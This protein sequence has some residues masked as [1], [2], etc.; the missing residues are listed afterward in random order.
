[1]RLSKSSSSNFS[2]SPPVAV[3]SIRSWN[4]SFAPLRM[5]AHKNH[6]RSRTGWWKWE[7]FSTLLGV[8]CRP[9]AHWHI[10]CRCMCVVPLVWNQRPITIISPRAAF[11][12]NHLLF[13]KLLP[14]Y[15]SPHKLKANRRERRGMWSGISSTWHDSTFYLEIDSSRIQSNTL[16]DKNESNLCV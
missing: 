14:I 7:E 2:L 9:E 12:S 13:L 16:Y 6:T 1:M 8:K 11:F 10:M 3:D 5:K 15:C 4:I